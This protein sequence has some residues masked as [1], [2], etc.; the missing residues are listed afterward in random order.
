MVTHHAVGDDLDAAERGE[1]EEGRERVSLP[2]LSRRNCPPT[3]QEMQWYTPDWSGSALR[4][5][6]RMG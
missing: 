4:R 1:F 5:D 2:R 6:M 3:T